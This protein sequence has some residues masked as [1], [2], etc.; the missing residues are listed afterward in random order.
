MGTGLHTFLLVWGRDWLDA[1]KCRELD[2]GRVWTGVGVHSHA[3][4]DVCIKK[5]PCS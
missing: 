4:S 3:G 2:G 1:S 5:V